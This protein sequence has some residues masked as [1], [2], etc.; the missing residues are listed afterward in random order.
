MSRDNHIHPS[1]PNC[2]I[3]NKVKIKFTSINNCDIYECLECK[4]AFTFPVPREMSKYYHSNYWITPGILGKIKA[5]IF[6]S[7]QRRR[8]IW[9]TDY[10]KKGKVLEVGSGEGNFEQDLGDDFDYTGVEFPA[11]KIKNKKILKVNLISWRTNQKF[12]AVIFWESLE[13]VDK[14][15]QYLQKTNKLLKKNGLLL[16]EL[17]RFDCSEVKLFKD[18]WFHLDPPRHLVHLSNPG[19]DTLLKRANFKIITK[20]SVLAMEYVIWGWTA[21]VLNYFKI[22]P[23]DYFKK[24]KNPILFILLIPLLAIATIVETVY[25]FLNESPIAFIAARK[26]NG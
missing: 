5:I 24:N 13:H 3:K 26:N 18:R 20:K 10:I 7:F 15:Q 22:V 6:K 17:P 1:C 4:N 16:I 14:P 2:L 25:Y 19:V 12:D 23:T 8:K 9:L 21:S 11:T